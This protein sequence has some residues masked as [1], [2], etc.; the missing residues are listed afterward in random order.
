MTTQFVNK[1]AIDTEE[2]FQIIN[3][4]EGIYESTLIKLLQCNRISLEARLKTLEKNKMISKQKI[5][6]HFFYT[7]TF[8]FKNMKPL[9]RQTN[10]VQKLVTYGI[11]TENIHIV[12]NCDH[13]KELY[14]SCYSSGRDTFQ[15]NEHLKLQANK[16]VNQ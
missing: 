3:N 13:Q 4:S 11:F 12:T 9:D 6:K 8:D 16:L 7:N 1:R 10:V 5:K 2:L 14:L 15:T